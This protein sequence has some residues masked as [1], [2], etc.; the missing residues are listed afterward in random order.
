MASKTLVNAEKNGSTAVAKQA[1]DVA[2]FTTTSTSSYSV[3][4]F[5][6]GQSLSS[7]VS[8]DGDSLVT[9]ASLKSQIESTESI[10][11]GLKETIKSY[12]NMKK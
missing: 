3:T 7:Y 9:S 6:L 4:K 5:N 8:V 1:F 12:E 11:K 2:G 10:I